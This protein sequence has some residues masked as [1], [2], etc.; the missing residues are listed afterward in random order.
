MTLRVPHSDS[1]LRPKHSEA[2]VGRRAG[3]TP[4]VSSSQGLRGFPVLWS[5]HGCIPDSPEMKVPLLECRTHPVQPPIVQKMKV[6]PRERKPFVSY[7]PAGLDLQ[8]TALGFQPQGS[9]QHTQGFPEHEWTLTLKSIRS[10]G[11]L[12]LCWALSN[13]V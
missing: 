2:S 1:V 5:C 10:Q 9:A 13:L 3:Q 8:A 7:N 4:E 11:V 12:Q 6:R